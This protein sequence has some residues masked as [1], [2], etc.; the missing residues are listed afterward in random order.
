MDTWKQGFLN[1]ARFG[2]WSTSS[3]SRPTCRLNLYTDLAPADNT[4]YLQCSRFHLHY[5]CG[6]L[7]LFKS[8][9]ISFLCLLADTLDWPGAIDKAELRRLLWDTGYSVNRLFQDMHQGPSSNEDVAMTEI[10][11]MQW[12]QWWQWWQKFRSDSAAPQGH[13]GWNLWR[14][15]QGQVWICWA[16]GARAAAPAKSN[17]NGFNRH[18]LSMPSM[19]SMLQM[20]SVGF[21]CFGSHSWCLAFHQNFRGSIA[22]AH[23][24]SWYGKVWARTQDSGGPELLLKSLW[25]PG[26]HQWKL[27]G[28]P[29]GNMKRTL[30]MKGTPERSGVRLIRI[31]VWPSHKKRTGLHC[32]GL[33]SLWF[34]KKRGQGQLDFVAEGHSPRGLDACQGPARRV[35]TSPILPSMAS[36]LWLGAEHLL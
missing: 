2:S 36:I 28:A 31:I 18:L 27:I 21:S 8:L 16:Q 4:I 14:G 35:S 32:Q 22:A 12:W 19:P 17:T 6:P 9:F 20:D 33:R 15:R 1:C 10:Y 29:C 30:W 7:I 23:S 25:F 26:S 3:L 34:F 13:L 24:C 5:S 11:N